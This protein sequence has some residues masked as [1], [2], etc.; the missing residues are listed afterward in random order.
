MRLRTKWAIALTVIGTVLLTAFM[1]GISNGSAFSDGTTGY[2]IM[3]GFAGA[4][5]FNLGTALL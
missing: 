4:L 2:W 5:S 3:L 1:V